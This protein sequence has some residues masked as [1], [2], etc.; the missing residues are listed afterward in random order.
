VITVDLKT[1]AIAI[2]I[3]IKSTGLNGIHAIAYKLVRSQGF[4]LIFVTA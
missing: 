3:T 2:T 1:T 4:E